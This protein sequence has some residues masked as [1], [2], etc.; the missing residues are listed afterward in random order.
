M[1]FYIHQTDDGRVPGFEFM[2]CSAII[3]KVGMAMKVTSGNLAVASAADKPTYISMTERTTACTAGDLIPVIR[4]NPDIIFEVSTPSSFSQAVGVKAKLGS[5]GISLQNA[6][7]GT[8]EIVYTDSSITRV[9]F[10]EPDA[11]GG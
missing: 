6:S 11:V 10:V 7:G 4:V 3:P 8:A 1:A 2:P 9:R 5:D